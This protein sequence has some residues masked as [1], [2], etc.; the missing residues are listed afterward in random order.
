MLFRFSDLAKACPLTDL[1]T[2]LF[3]HPE[4][5]IG[6]LTAAAMIV[7][8]VNGGV[9]PRLRVRILDFEP[10]V[11]FKDIK[12]NLVGKLVCVTGTIIRVGAIRS[13]VMKM[14][15]ECEQCGTVMQMVRVSPVFHL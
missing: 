8:A 9:N 4:D 1:R 12:A 5:T 7:T 15:F 14:N 11:A 2:A 3:D 13:M 10:T 6:C